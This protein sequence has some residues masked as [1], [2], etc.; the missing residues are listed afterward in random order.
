MDADALERRRLAL[1]KM[2]NAK[3]SWYHVRYL[4]LVIFTCMLIETPEQSSSLESDCTLKPVGLSDTVVIPM[5]TISSLST[6][7]TPWLVTYIILPP[8]PCLPPQIRPSK[9]PRQPAQS[10]DSS[11][12]VSWRTMLVAREYQF[13]YAADFSN[14]RCTVLN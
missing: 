10:L 2:D 11:V 6:L 13:F 5:L 7:P 14:L 1:E 9:F 3:F 12:L 4:I 8:V